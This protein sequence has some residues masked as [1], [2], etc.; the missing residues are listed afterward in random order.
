MADALP[1]G[2]KPTDGLAHYW[3]K[4]LS[5][6]A[7]VDTAAVATD[8]AERH[9]IYSL[10]TMALVRAYWNGNKFGAEGDYPTRPSQKKRNGSYEG[11]RIGDRA[12]ERYIGHNIACIAVDENGEIIDFE[13][14]HNELYNSSAEHAESRLI[15]RIFTLNQAYNH[16]QTLAEGDLADIAYSNV[17]NGVTI[18]TSLESCA[19]C[20]GVMT[21][22]SCLR[23]VYLQSD[24]GQY[25]VGNLLYNLS[26]PQPAPAFF[27]TA[28]ALRPK[29][30]AKY[31]APE[32]LGADLFGFE[33][34]AQLDT[35]YS[36]FLK[37]GQDEPQAMFWVSPDGAKKKR[38]DSLTSF[39]CTDAARDIY[40]AAA[41]EFGSLVPTHK[42][43]K[44]PRSDG[45]VEAVKSNEEALDH[46]RAFLRHAV[47]EARRG[48]PHR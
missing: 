8:Q 21:L 19:Q 34:K 37:S 15:R 23:V 29:P 27:S 16:W 33:Y 3:A 46:A 6:L 13:F 35:A 4:P 48:T 24:P 44:P 41:E 25:L 10:L 47:K 38:P 42:T 5:D 14:N 43:F 9:R 26:R 28:E 31:W 20:S 17:F 36:A 30:T 2:I 7:K 22:A 39:L 12:S 18:Y 11:E 32:P 1:P 40:G 45:E